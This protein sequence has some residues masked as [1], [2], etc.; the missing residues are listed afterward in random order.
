M[1]D[2][3]S[4]HREAKIAARWEHVPTDEQPR[5]AVTNSSRG[6]SLLNALGHARHD[7]PALLAE[8]AA[9]RA[10]RD[11][12]REQVER[13]EDRNG[14]LLDQEAKDDDE[15]SQVLLERDRY[16]SAWQSARFRAQAYGE[17]ILRHVADR[18]TWKSWCKQAQAGGAP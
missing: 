9:V 17:G 14:C 8:L 13:L 18:D 2:R 1:S 7:V 11:E 15:F 5:I 16:R 4:P 3:L 12:A 10:E 6:G